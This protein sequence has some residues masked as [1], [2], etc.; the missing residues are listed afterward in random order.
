MK[1]VPRNMVFHV[2]LVCLV[3]LTTSCTVKRFYVPEP[4]ELSPFLQ[5]KED[6]HPVCSVQLINAQTDTSQRPIG[7]Y[8]HKWWA[9]LRLWTDASIDLLADELEKREVKLS[10]RSPIHLKL[11]ITEADLFWQF[12]KVGCVVNLWVE[13]GNGYTINIEEKNVAHDLYNSCDGAVSK[14]IATLLETSEIRKYLS[15]TP[16]IKDSDCDGVPDDKDKC[17]DTPLKAA[18]DKDGCALDSD[19]DGVPDYK[20]KCPDTPQGAK[21]DKHGCWNIQVPLFEFDKYSIKP[22]Y[23]SIL[24]RVA[25][26]I[27]NNPGLKIEIQGHADIIGSK[28]YNQELSLQRA[29]SVRSYLVNQGVSADRLDVK[30]FGYSRPRAS[31]QTE[32]G[33]AKN[34]RVEFRPIKN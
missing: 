2:G 1:Y 11:S 7:N 10:E 24:D 9:N 33:R 16:V 4:K 31:S 14:A 21:V 13:A 26:V 23:Y 32:K 8:S 3:L 22:K 29:K 15:S 5:L 25:R 34:R 28:Q 17:P 19:G 6:F 27:K 30:G 18:V 20:D 12:K